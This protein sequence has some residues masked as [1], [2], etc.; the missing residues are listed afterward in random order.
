[1][2]SRAKPRT[3]FRVS[4]NAAGSEEPSLKTR[5]KKTKPVKVFV[6]KMNSR[7]PQ[8]SRASSTTSSTCT[9]KGGIPE[10]RRQECSPHSAPIF[11]TQRHTGR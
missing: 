8:R 10:S 11:A 7:L 4:T 9:L 3:L 6:L 2:T 5:E 1:M